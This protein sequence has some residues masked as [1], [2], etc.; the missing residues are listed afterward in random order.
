MSDAEPFDAYYTESRDRLLVLAFALTG[1][2][3]ASRGA[4]RDYFIAAWH[5]WSRLRRL[6]DPGTW[7]RPRVWSHAQRRPTA[8]IWHRDRKLD[9]EIRATLDGLAKLSTTSRKLLPL[10]RLTA[11]TPQESAREVGLTVDVAEARLREATTQFAEQR[12]VVESQVRP[13][14][15]RLVEHCADQR[16]PRATI[17]RRSGTTRRRTHTL[18]GA[19]L[20]VV[21]VVGS[22]F[23]VT[24]QHGVRPTLAAAGDRLTAV[25]AGGTSGQQPP[26][27]QITPS[28]L[29]STAQ[30]RR[31]VPGRTWRITGTDPTQGMTF[32]CQRSQYADPHAATALVRNFT[33]RRTHGRPRLAVVQA[34]ELSDSVAAAQKGYAAASGWFASCTLPRMQLLGVRRIDRLGEQAAQYVLRSWT[35][36]AATFV[37]GLART[38]RVNTVTLTRTSGT[39]SPDLA[40]GVRVLTAAV[41]DLCPTTL[42]GHCSAMPHAVD[43]PAPPAGDP[44]MMLTEL[45][46]PPAA[47]VTRPWVGTTPKQARQNAAATGCDS[48]SFHGRGWQHTATRSFLVPGGR[49]AAAFGITETVGRL[50]A[51]RASAF[52]ADVRSKLASC[53]HRELGTKVQRLAG[54]STWTAW[55]VRTEVSTKETVT[56]FMGIVRAGGAVAQVGFV[57]DGSHTMTSADFVALVRRAGE[58]LTAF[59]D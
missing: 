17:I 4:V 7:L 28:S 26:E 1:D 48:S 50:P 57:A 38:G 31:A 37:L 42:G 14:L 21:A 58:R 39:G 35:A 27:E 25:P 8:R 16:W 29:I 47:G 55:R 3:S 20:V 6:E 53:S 36:P 18:A 15:S 52:V 56:F 2:L 24:D 41:D 49:L 51:A 12:G 44:P 54:G 46:L 40:G 33:A 32:P 5:H 59:P 23:L 34:T 9:P 45:D 43:V 19:A 11:A 30:L 13:T 10:S 22:G